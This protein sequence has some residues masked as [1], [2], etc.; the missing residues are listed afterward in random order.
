[1]IYYRKDYFSGAVPVTLK[2]DM[3]GL[4]Q[5]FLPD[6]TL[7]DQGVQLIAGTLDEQIKAVSSGYK[8]VYYKQQLTDVDVKGFPDAKVTHVGQFTG[9]QRL[10]APK[11]DDSYRYDPEEDSL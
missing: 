6:G 3:N 5:A 9:S 8:R 4:Y 1:M 10:Q 11:E 2:Q 7:L